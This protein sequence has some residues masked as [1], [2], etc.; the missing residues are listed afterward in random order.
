MAFCVDGE[1]LS[2]SGQFLKLPRLCSHRLGATVWSES[3]LQFLSARSCG[4]AFFCASCA[5]VD[6]SSTALAPIRT[7]RVF[8]DNMMLSLAASITLLQSC[9]RC[10]LRPAVSVHACGGRVLRRMPRVPF[11]KMQVNPF[12]KC[13]LSCPC[14]RIVNAFSIVSCLCLCPA[15]HCFLFVY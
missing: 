7:P 10:G 12:C 11:F 5:A 9:H 3:C 4:Q 14:P 2:A 15:V 13:P 6:S 1:R 8:H